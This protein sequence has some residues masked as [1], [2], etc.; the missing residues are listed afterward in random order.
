MADRSCEDVRWLIPELAL[1]VAPGD[2]RAHALAHLDRC[3]Q[4]RELLE[5]ATTTA[6]DLLVLAPEHEPPTGFDTRVLRAVSAP[7]RRRR[8]AAALVAAAVAIA[9]LGAAG[10]T[11]RAG[12]DE[13]EAATAYRQTRDV[14]D[15]SHLSAA[16]LKTDSGVEAGHV[17]AFQGE[18]SWIFM[19]VD[20][21]PSGY[22][23]VTLVTKDGRVREVGWCRVHDGTASWGTAVDVPIDSVDHLEMRHDAT[24]MEA[25][26]A[27]PARS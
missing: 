14:G 10:V 9:G 6:D 19:T 4:C 27:V 8:R 12:A 26:L 3:P 1:G 22:Y 24:V 7:R 11:W 20:G 25:E 23:S 13:R 18:P 2:E 5:R 16:V 15:G 17:F 21:A